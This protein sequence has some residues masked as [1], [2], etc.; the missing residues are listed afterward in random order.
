MLDNDRPRIV[1]GSNYQGSALVEF[2]GGLVAQRDNSGPQA[3]LTAPIWR[4]RL[5]PYVCL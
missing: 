5:N 1:E 4:T 2:A 3:G